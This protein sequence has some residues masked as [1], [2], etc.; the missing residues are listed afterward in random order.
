MLVVATGLTV[1]YT[2]RLIFYRLV[3]DFNLS[4]RDNVGDDRSVITWPM[5][6]LGGGSVFGGAALAWLIFPSPYII[7]LPLGV[8]LLALLVRVL[9]A[10][11]GYLL[12]N[13][14]VNYS[15][16]SLKRYTLVVFSGSI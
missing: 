14:N 4:V 6:A 7:C 1:C 3:R 2:F 10:L 15:L 12:N 13:I 5:L 16:I 8:K 9:G 11:V